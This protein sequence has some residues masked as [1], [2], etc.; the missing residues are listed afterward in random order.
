MSTDTLVRP[1]DEGGGSGRI[2]CR[3]CGTLDVPAIYLLDGDWVNEEIR[4]DAMTGHRL[5]RT[6]M[7]A[8]ELDRQFTA[9]MDTVYREG[10]WTHTPAQWR[11]VVT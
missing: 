10:R 5:S 8:Q 11:Q 7:A 3:L 2:S 4:A 9:H 1:S 6:H